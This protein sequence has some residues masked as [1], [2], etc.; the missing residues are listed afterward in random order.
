[1]L[2]KSVLGFLL[3]LTISIALTLSQEAWAFERHH[4]EKYPE[5][6]GKIVERVLFL[7]NN[8]TQESI[9]QREMRTV[10]GR[11]F[12]TTDL[13][14]DWERLTDLGLFAEVEVDAVPSGEGVLVVVSVHERPS[15]FAAPV[16]DYD[17]GENRITA[18]FQARLLNVRGLN[19]QLR[20]RFVTGERHVSTLS[21]SNPWVRSSK[22]SLGM[23]FRVDLPGTSE[24]RLRIFSAGLATTKF[25]GD[26]KRVRQGITASTRMEHLERDNNA[27]GGGIEQ[28]SPTLGLS[29]SRDTRNVRIDPDRGSFFVAGSEYATGLYSSDLNY[30]RST[31]DARGF[32]PL[33]GRFLLAGRSNTVFTSGNVPAYRLISIGG[34][35]LD[36]RTRVGELDRGEFHPRCAGTAHPTLEEQA[37][38]LP[39]STSPEEDGE[40]FQHRLSSGRSALFGRRENLVRNE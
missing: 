37:H 40:D 14:H 29:W 17:I 13:W 5:L 6:E 33:G 10:P 16:L 38:V 22:Q 20:T 36:S 25:V 4:Y 8:K 3:C 1:M 12:K 21:W 28:L 34:G 15:W 30:V 9:F 35:W 27:L 39:A 11:P 32:V 31:I 18:G 19:Q 23:D 24:D 2:F 7:G 26:Y